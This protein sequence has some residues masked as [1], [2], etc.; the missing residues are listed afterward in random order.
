MME[1]H[2][3]VGAP[4]YRG[5]ALDVLLGRLPSLH[6]L[7]EGKRLTQGRLVRRACR[8]RGSATASSFDA[9]TGDSRGA[10]ARGRGGR[11]QH[12]RGGDRRAARAAVAGAADRAAGYWLDVEPESVAVEPV[13]A[14]AAWLR[15]QAGRR[16]RRPRC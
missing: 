16:G 11:P 13:I 2:A 14:F 4:R 5:D 15:E 1:R 6:V 8:R 10:R 7:H 9:R 3:L 12:D